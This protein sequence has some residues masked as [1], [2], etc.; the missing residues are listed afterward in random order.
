MEEKVRYLSRIYQHPDLGIEDIQKLAAVHEKVSFKKGDFILQKGEILNEYYILEKGLFRSFVHDYQGNDITIDFFSENDILIEV[1]SLFQRIP[2]QENIEALTDSVAYK[3]DFTDFQELFHKLG[4]FSEW[5]RSW[6]SSSLF[7]FK[8]RSTLMRVESAR[9]R[10][11]RLLKEKPTV[12]K[13][14]PLK[15]IASYLGITDSTL[16]RIRKVR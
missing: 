7:S 5:G 1:S 10:Y 4:G 16:S 3:I 11:E 14:A 8:N 9:E 2:T 13:M 6:M 12:G 15:H